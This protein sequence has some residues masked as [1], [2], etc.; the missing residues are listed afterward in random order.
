MKKIGLAF[1]VVWVIVVGYIAF[2]TD[3]DSKHLSCHDPAAI[4]IQK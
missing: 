3:D 4:G 1:C 2:F